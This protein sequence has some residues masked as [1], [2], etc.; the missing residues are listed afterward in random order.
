MKFQIETETVTCISSQIVQENNYEGKRADRLR[1]RHFMLSA[2]ILGWMCT[3]DRS[4]QTGRDVCNA[5]SPFNFLWRKKIQA[6]RFRLSNYHLSCSSSQSLLNK[7][8]SWKQAQEL[9]W[10]CWFFCTIYIWNHLKEMVA[11]DVQGVSLQA[12]LRMASSQI[13]AACELSYISRNRFS[14]LFARNPQ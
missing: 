3:V 4:I 5:L 9:L 13:L 12:V 7:K 6:Y 1:S 14:K 10:F 11:K 2:S 8:Y